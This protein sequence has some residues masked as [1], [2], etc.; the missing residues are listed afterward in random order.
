MDVSDLQHLRSIASAVSDHIRA[1]FPYGGGGE[2]IS[3]GASGDWTKEIDQ[4][5]ETIALNKI[6]DM[7]M[8]WNILSE[9]MGYLDRGAEKTL[10]MDPIDGTYNA[11]N[12]LPFYSTSLAIRGAEGEIEAGVVCDIPMR[13]SFY[14]ERGKGAYLDGDRISTREYIESRSVF[15]S[16]LDPGSM[17]KN[18]FLL[19]WPKRSRYFG[20]VS[21]EVCFVAKG[22]FDLFA[23]FSRLPRITDLA[24]SYLILKEAGGVH[25]KVRKDGTWAEY[26]PVKESDI[27]G[28]L[29]IGDPNAADRMIEL[30]KAIRPQEEV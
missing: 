21:L 30:C 17:E 22:S 3:L 19:S 6:R 7:G 8:D 9:E 26:Y 15:S 28:V 14:A 12:G 16:F 18:R 29:A 27:R 13:R 10:I 25:L 2:R 24:A 4:Q 23:L 20:A 1:T 11:V 5:A